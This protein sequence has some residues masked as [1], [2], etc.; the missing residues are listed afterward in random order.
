MDIAMESRR[1]HGID[2]PLSGALLVA[3][4]W[5]AATVTADEGQVVPARAQLLYRFD[6]ESGDRGDGVCAGWGFWKR[7]LCRTWL[8]TAV[9]KEGRYS[10]AC[11]ANARHGGYWSPRLSIEP[12]RLYRLSFWV[13]VER[14]RIRVKGQGRLI[15][16]G[17]EAP[18]VKYARHF[19]RDMVSLNGSI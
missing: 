17:N 5:I 13:R 4:L 9:K 19:V 12:G 10:Q 8:D 6:F 16:C 15:A 2:L 1:R 7:E 14:G 3:G 11:D 18:L